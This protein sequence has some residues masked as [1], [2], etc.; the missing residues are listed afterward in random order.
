[1]QATPYLCAVLL[2]GVTFAGI[3]PAS[4]ANCQVTTSSTAVPVGEIYVQ[5][6][7]S[8]WRESNELPG[9]QQRASGCSDG[10]S[11]PS[12]RCIYFETPLTFGC[13]LKYVEDET[14][15]LL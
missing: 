14:E 8:Y 9:L 15:I 1:V 11:I 5:G 13:T 3:S 12:D 4:A 10:T 2:A 7:G 6:A